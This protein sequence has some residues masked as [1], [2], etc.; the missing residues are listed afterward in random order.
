MDKTERLP[1]PA[2]TS[3]ERSQQSA[4]RLSLLAAATFVVLLAALHAIRPDLDP[5]V[6]RDQ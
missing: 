3:A 2:T 6:A 5:G 1:T 4:A